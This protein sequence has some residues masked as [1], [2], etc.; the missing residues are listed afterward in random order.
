[1]SWSEGRTSRRPISRRLLLAAL[2]L[3]DE[4]F[5]TRERAEDLEGAGDA[6]DPETM[7]GA[8]RAVAAAAQRISEMAAKLDG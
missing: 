6:L 7:G 8:S 5:E 3:C 4:L 1:M 2:T